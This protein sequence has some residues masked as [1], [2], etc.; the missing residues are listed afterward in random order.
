MEALPPVAILCGGA[1]ARLR[2]LTDTV[3]KALVP[4]H[5][6]PVIEHLIEHGVAEGFKKFILCIGHKGEKIIE[7]FT[8]HPFPGATFEYSD[9]GVDASMLQRIAAVRGHFAERVVLCYGDT[10]TD[11]DFRRLLEQHRRNRAA[12]TVAAVGIQNPFGLLKFDRDDRALSF[13]EKPTL[14]YYIGLSVI[15]A[16]A[17]DHYATPDLTNKMDGVGLV[18]FFQRILRD[19]KLFIYRHEGLQITFNTDAERQLAE[20]KL[21][22]FYTQQENT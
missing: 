18:E 7:H 16:T 15:E 12:A 5:G 21:V 6:R 1:G 8:Q 19:G 9:A 4:V 22:H 14:H 11:I 3:P 2:P 20:D 13:E 10:I 17:F